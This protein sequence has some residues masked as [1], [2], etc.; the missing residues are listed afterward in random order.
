MRRREFIT[1]V[2][3]A[4]AAWPLAAHAQQAGK[5]PTIGYLGDDA[6]SWSPWTARFVERLNELGWNEGQ[7]ISI[8]YR[9]SEGH[10]ERI[11]EIATEFAR[12][13]VS[14]I[15]TYGGAVAALKQATAAIPIVF[16][17][18]VDPIGSGIVASLSHPGGNVT[19]LSVEQ[20]DIAGKRLEL[21]R[22]IVPKL[23][24]LAIMF[25]GGYAAAVRENNETQ[26]A[27]RTF[28][29]DVVSHAIRRAA[30]IVP[31]F[32]AIK[33][34]ADALYIAVDALI[35]ANREQIA[36]TALSA[37]LPTTFN[38]SG[39]VEVG[40]LMSYGPN[41]S[42]QFRRTAEIVDKILRGTKPGD[43]PVE[44]PIKFELSINLKTAKA[45]GLTVPQTLLAT[46]D[47][48]IE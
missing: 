5:L 30:D 45:L 22:E 46:A 12:R 34:Q 41:F 48:V 23:R 7:N 44:Q 6:S 17:I 42:D 3:G 10:P 43:I 39:C 26:A 20:S 24:R 21:L 15:I 1:L 37:R 4:G 13:N 19:G 16:A 29:L 18:A 32:E 27:A 36:R 31:A 14:V 9:W 38:E 35:N 8:E 25:D 33:S 40:G 2:C 11:A 47:K 28:G